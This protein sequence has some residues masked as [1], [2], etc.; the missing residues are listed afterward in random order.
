MTL[1]LIEKDRKPKNKGETGSRYE[2]WYMREST[3]DFG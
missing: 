3:F 2:T 1:S